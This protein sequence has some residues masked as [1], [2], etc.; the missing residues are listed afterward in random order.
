M[1]Y[2]IAV[3]EPIADEIASWGLPVDTEDDLFTRLAEGLTQESLDRLWRHPGPGPV[4][5]YRLEFQDALVLGIT[6]HFTFWL[7]YGPE[8]DHLY[9]HQGEYGSEEDWDSDE[10]EDA[11]AEPS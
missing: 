11:D 8:P 10:Q 1:T 5:I 4:Y 3:P 7:T 6:H 2:V 9:I